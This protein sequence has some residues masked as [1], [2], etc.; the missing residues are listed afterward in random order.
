MSVTM[1]SSRPAR[2]R[3]AA[4]F[5]AD[6]NY[7]PY[8]L[9]AADQLRRSSGIHD[10]DILI[11]APDGCA[12]PKS[13]EYLDVRLCHLDAGDL[14]KGLYLDGRVTESA[15]HRLALPAALKEEYDRILY[16]DCDIFIHGGD[17]AALFEIDLG[18]HA[19]AAVRD[20]AQWESP[21]FHLPALKDHGLPNAKYFNSGVQ[22]VDTKAFHDQEIL[23]QC[24]AF[25]RENI[26]KMTYH[27]Q[28]LLNCVLQ[29][30]WKEISP[31]WNWQH[32]VG[33]PPF[34][35]KVAVSISHF[36]GPKK[37]WNDNRGRVSPR[38]TL[39]MRGFLGQ[40][41][42]ELPTIQIKK[43]RDLPAPKLPKLRLRKLFEARRLKRYLDRFPDDLGVAT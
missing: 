5:C 19:I 35:D 21:E 10:L 7:L 41:F 26:A 18:G 29:G 25:G 13:L 32:I 34:I 6:E 39:P 28:Q 30:E 1:S 33:P 14:F 17:F 31:V 40:H 9:F 37:P 24:I 15:Y 11:C 16:L 3:Y 2:G 20:F 22:L 8:A 4:A 36:I 42:P 27:D 38:Y 43:A 12:V 23:G